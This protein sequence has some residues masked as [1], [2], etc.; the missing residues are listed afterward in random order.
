MPRLAFAL[1]AALVAA[2][3]DAA[4]SADAGIDP[5]C[6]ACGAD[7]ICVQVLDGTCTSLGPSCVPRV[8]GCE[9]DTCSAAC[10][11]AY[12]TGVASSTCQAAPC[13]TDLVGAYHCYGP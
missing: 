2:C 1:C 3:G 8:A 7:E 4:T 11:Q 13:T 12:C 6:A 5:R 10:D 9:A